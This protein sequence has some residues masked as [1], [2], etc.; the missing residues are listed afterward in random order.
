MGDLKTF[1]ND[2]PV[3]DADT[4][5]NGTIARGSDPNADGNDGPAGLNSA[6]TSNPP[7]MATSTEESANS[8]SKLPKLP[9]RFEPSVPSTVTPANL[10]NR[11]PS[12]VDSQ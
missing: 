5:G 2:S 6:W 11:S 3:P 8:V 7:A 10:E 1:W 12:N 4:A 9:N